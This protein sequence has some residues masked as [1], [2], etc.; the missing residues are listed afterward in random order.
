MYFNF[1]ISIFSTHALLFNL[2]FKILTIEIHLDSQLQSP[3]QCDVSKH[4]KIIN[5]QN[6][7]P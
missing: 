2:T 3:A 1:R 7:N 5:L 6:I 4:A